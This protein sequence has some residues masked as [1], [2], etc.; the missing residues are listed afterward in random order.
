[1][2]VRAVLDTLRHVWLTIEEL[3]I[4]A[5]VV[6]GLALAFWKHPRA[7]RDVDVMVSVTD[8]QL[9]ELVSALVNTGVRLKSEGA[10]VH[11]GNTDIVQ[12]E[13][14]PPEAFVDV[15]LDLLI[16]RSPYARD[17]LQRSIAV[18]SEQLGFAIRVLGCEDLII[19]KLL[20]ARMIDLADAAALVRANIGS[21]DMRYLKDKVDQLQLSRQLRQIWEEAFPGEP[22]P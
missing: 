20:A 8:A 12:L 7:T 17:A 5:A 11:L 6:G 15:P 14:E 13:Y 9:E 22:L 1:M 3:D 21:L 10:R 19:N 18:T 2:A 4:T 16:A